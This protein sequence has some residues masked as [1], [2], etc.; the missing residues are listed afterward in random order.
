MGYELAPKLVDQLPEGLTMTTEMHEVSGLTGKLG[1]YN[2]ERAHCYHDTV[3]GKPSGRWYFPIS[4]I[5][6]TIIL[7]LPHR[8]GYVHSTLATHRRTLVTRA[9]P[10]AYLHSRRYP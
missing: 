10:S 2:G 6:D 5:S 8:S 4:D 1:V 9:S 7:A 3:D